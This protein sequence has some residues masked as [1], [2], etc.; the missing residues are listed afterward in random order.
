MNCVKMGSCTITTSYVRYFDVKTHT[1]NVDDH[2]KTLI[3]KQNK[4]CHY[5]LLNY[6][7]CINQQKLQQPQSEMEICKHKKRP[8]VQN[9][10]I[11]C[12]REKKKCGVNFSRKVIWHTYHRKS[13]KMTCTEKLSALAHGHTYIFPEN[14]L[15]QLI[16]IG[17][18]LH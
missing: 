6:S 5:H 8:C 2:E 10:W 17:I 18:K 11:F 7:K 14:L 13:Y 15:F 9:Q 12:E 4:D 16:E 1:H 3:S